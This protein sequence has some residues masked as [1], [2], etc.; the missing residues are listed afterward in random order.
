MNRAILKGNTLH[1]G[2]KNRNSWQ[3]SKGITNNT[4][5][6]TTSKF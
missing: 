2:W 4:A 1:L 6:T 5:S 3:Y